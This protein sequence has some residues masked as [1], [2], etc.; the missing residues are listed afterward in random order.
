MVMFYEWRA[1]S[2]GLETTVGCLKNIQYTVIK[3]YYRTKHTTLHTHNSWKNTHIQTQRDQ[4]KDTNQ[5]LQAKKE[6]FCCKRVSV[7]A[8]GQ[9][10]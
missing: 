10:V 8:K 4:H 2:M 1:D 9:T 3:L 7:Q 5:H 6:L